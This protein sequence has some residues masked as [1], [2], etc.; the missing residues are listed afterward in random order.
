MSNFW[1]EKYWLP[2]NVLWEQIPPNFYDLIYPIY[3]AIPILI[4]RILL[5]SFFG[6]SMGVLLGVVPRQELKSRIIDHLTG[7][8][9]RYTR[10]K[11]ILECMFRCVCY[12]L[13]FLYGLFVLW[14]KPWLTDVTQCWIGYPYHPIESTVWYVLLT[15]FIT[16]PVFCLSL[17]PCIFALKASIKGYRNICVA[18]LFK[19]HVTKQPL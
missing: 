16:I 3:F 9:A 5:E 6:I 14:D 18:Y 12:F 7:G 8:F 1:K 13:L 10:S 17:L 2:R 19:G 4:F 11:R 15:F